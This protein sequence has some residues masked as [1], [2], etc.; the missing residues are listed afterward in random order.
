MKKIIKSII[1]LSVSVFIVSGCG[2]HRK[3]RHKNSSYPYTSSHTMRPAHSMSDLDNQSRNV[4]PTLVYSYPKSVNMGNA[5]FVELGA[6]KYKL[7]NYLNSVRAHNNS[8]GQAAPPVT[9]NR[10]LELASVAHSK[11]MAVNNFLGHLG[12]GKAT[13][14]ARKGPGQGSNFY[15]RIM[16]SGYPIKPGSLAGEVIT[17]T[18]FRIVGNQEPYEHFVH[19]INNFLKS[20]AHCHIMMNPRFKD[21]GIAAYKDKEKIYWTIEFGEIKY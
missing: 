4:K 1:V 6:V 17:Y 3:V 19:A 8:C 16:Y 21:V 13:D 5:T 20:P 9:W 2:Y 18:K 11:D 10:E 15:E 7:L 12:S 14:P